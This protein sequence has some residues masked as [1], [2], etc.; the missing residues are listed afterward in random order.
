MTNEEA[1]ESYKYDRAIILI[2]RIKTEETH[3][4]ETDRH[5]AFDLAI[6]ALEKQIPKKPIPH[7]V[8]FIEAPIKIGN[9]NWCEGTTV[10]KCPCCNEF[11]STLYKCCYK[12]G[13]KIDWSDRE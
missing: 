9:A 13:Q 11:I 7:K 6:S 12:C 1:I 5:K 4:R 10:Y 3:E 2:K 8:E